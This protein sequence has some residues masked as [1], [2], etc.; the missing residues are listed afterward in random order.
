MS[1]ISKKLTSRFNQI[2]RLKESKKYITVNEYFTQV[3]AI[4]FTNSRHLKEEKKN[5][6]KLNRKIT[7]YHLL[8]PYGRLS[9][10]V[11]IMKSS[12]RN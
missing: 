11:V 9:F 3:K 1:K 8:K 6:G 10:K 2:T 4:I 7:F 5:F 12:Q